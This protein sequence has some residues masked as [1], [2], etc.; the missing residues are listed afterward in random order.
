MT[1]TVVSMMTSTNGNI[2]RVTDPL[3]GESTGHWCDSPHKG[4]S[5]GALMF[6]LI[7]AWINGWANKAGAD[8]LATSSHS[9]RRQTNGLALPHCFDM[10][11]TALHRISCIELYICIKI[12]IWYCFAAPPQLKQHVV[13]QATDS[14]FLLNTNAQLVTFWH[15]I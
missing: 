10:L 8:D 12:D 5:R 1:H 9:L 13:L 2:F 3:W 15:L 4:Q 14:D 6:S 7:C 11:L